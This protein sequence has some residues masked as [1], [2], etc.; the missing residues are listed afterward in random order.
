MVR[1]IVVGDVMELVTI[2]RTPLSDAP[3]GDGGS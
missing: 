1:A 3:S 2:E